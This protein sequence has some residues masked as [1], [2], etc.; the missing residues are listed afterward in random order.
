MLARPSAPRYYGGLRRPRRYGRRSPSPPPALHRRL[1]ER[2][3]APIIGIGSGGNR[4]S[5]RAGG[6]IDQKLRRY[7]AG[8]G[9]DDDLVAAYLFGSV[10]R[11]RDHARSDVDVAVLYRSDPPATFDSLPL[12][13]E[14]EIERFLGRRTEVICLNM[15]PVD[16]CVRVL[17]DGVLLLDTRGARNPKPEVARKTAIRVLIYPT[18]CGQWRAG[19]A[20]WGGAGK[21]LRRR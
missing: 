17:R 14:G 3:A 20:G 9:T 12:R 21:R 13:L 11:G 10:A 4:M 15:A 2:P 1:G 6:V 5:S 7:F 16:L 19:V 18:L 8:R